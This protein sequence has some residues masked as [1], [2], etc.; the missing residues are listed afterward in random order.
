M[1][2][3]VARETERLESVQAELRAFEK[4]AAQR[5]AKASFWQGR[6]ILGGIL[7]LLLGM[8]GAVGGAYAYVETNRAPQAPTILIPS[9]APTIQVPDGSD[10]SEPPDASSDHGSV[11][12]EPSDASE[13]FSDGPGPAPQSHEEEEEQQQQEKIA[14]AVVVLIGAIFLLTSVC[15]WLARGYRRHHA[16]STA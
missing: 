14:L 15:C 3:T 2:Y 4:R 5:V 13:H 16:I 12:S 8:L 1:L 9:P 7:L 6:L 11:A 10:E